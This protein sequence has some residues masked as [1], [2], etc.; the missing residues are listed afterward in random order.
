MVSDVPST[1]STS[2]LRQF[3]GPYQQMAPRMSVSAGICSPASNIM[4]M[5]R[6]TPAGTK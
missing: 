1:M 5:S 6:W 3:S 4:L 2:R